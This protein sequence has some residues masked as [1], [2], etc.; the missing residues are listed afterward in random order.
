MNTIWKILLSVLLAAMLLCGCQKQQKFRI[1][2][3]QC[4]YDDWREK[5][6]EEINREILL[7]ND[8]EV[9][10]VSAYDNPDKQIA[11]IQSFI[12]RK[13]DI[14]IASPIEADVISPVIRRAKDAGIPTIMFDRNINDKCYTAYLGADNTVLGRSVGEYI[15]ALM[16]RQGDVIELKGLPGSTPAI[17]RHEG[18]MN[19]LSH[20]PDIKL[21][22]WGDADWT[23]ERGA[24]VVDSLLT[25]YPTAKAIFAQNDRMAIAARQ[26]AINHGLPN[27]I[28]VGI[29]AVAEVGIKAVADGVINA[30][31]LYPTGG[32]ELVETAYKILKGEAYQPNI[33]LSSVHPVDKSNA[34][35]LLLLSHSIDNETEKVAYLKGQV[36]EFT[37]KH[38]DQQALLYS[39]IVIIALS[40]GII[41]MLLRTF[42]SRKQHQQ[43]LSEQNQQ[44]KIQRDELQ[45]LNEQLKEATQAKL[46]FFTNVSHDLRTPL[47]LISEPVSQLKDADNLDDR[48]RVMMQLAD[49]NVKILQRLINQILDFR[50][51]ENGKL[52]LSPMEVNLHDCVLEWVDAF[53]LLALKK[54]IHLNVDVKS[55]ANNHVALDPEKMERVLFNLLSNAFKYTPAN[56][57]ITVTVD[58]VDGEIKIDVSDTGEGMSETDVNRI[59]ERFYQVDKVRPKGSGIGLALVKAFVE[60]HGGKI[61]VKSALGQGS[62][63]SVTV[64]VVHID[65]QIAVAEA[66][67]HDDMVS[68]ELGDIEPVEVEIDES[69]PCVLVIDDT[70]DIRTMIRGLL[71][72]KYCVIEASNGKQGIKMATKYIPDLIICDVMMP[73][74]DGLECCKILKNEA[75]TSHIQILLL[76]A[77]SLDEQRVEGYE[78][79]ADG[80]LSKPFNS[81]VLLARVNSLI[82]NRKRISGAGEELALHT[83]EPRHAPRKPKKHTGDIDNEFYN[84]FLE[85]VQAEMSNSD[86]TVE[87][88]GAR[89]GLSRVQFYRKIKALTNYSPNELLRNIRL[90]TAYK[91]L[92]ATEDTIA[93]VAYHVGFASPSYFSKCFKEYFGELP[94]DVQRRTSKIST[95]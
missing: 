51:Y 75:T 77:C 87:D 26:V 61:A 21:L 60:L 84:R 70:A 59:F 38:N 83:L 53:K 12:D 32:S 55:A 50:K 71:S 81:K 36:D 56:G 14:I 8:A 47:T 89:L 23:A 95:K 22:G 24:S 74:M 5:L 42:W 33:I 62:T 27:I 13:F 25:L 4:S 34:E 94:A 43:E 29:D 57:T 37:E 6:N 28:I 91:M 18:F 49:K 92:T 58:I 63:F 39:F 45:K 40:A 41:F 66:N 86:I 19:A 80:Y 93:E 72:D 65:D 64:P 82:E 11:D 16:G 46:V 9:E 90:K 69:E 7:H 88:I 85:V 67:I 30:T 68:G 52:Q 17:E 78:S 35:I 54:H 48:Q 79:G 31:F 15:A 73:E 20:Y 3:S 2:V 76:T 1:G 10:I 44:L